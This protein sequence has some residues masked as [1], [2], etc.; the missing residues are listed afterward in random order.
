MRNE[1][2]QEHS[3]PTILLSAN[4]I[5]VLQEPKVCRELSPGGM[6]MKRVMDL[7]ISGAAFLILLP[8]MILIALLIK[9]TFARSNILPLECYRQRRSTLRWL[10]VPDD[11]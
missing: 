6:A 1:T 8:L 7:V 4:H 10:Q 11:V 2:Q 9:L 5:S 3:G